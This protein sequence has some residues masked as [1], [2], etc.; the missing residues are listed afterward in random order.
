MSRLVAG[1]VP[2]PAS[3]PRLVL[4]LEIHI[5]QGYKTYWR[6]PGDA[7]G[8]PPRFDWSKS[9]NLKS[10]KTLFPA[11]QRITD[12]AGALIGYKEHIVFPI[13]VEAIDPARPIRLVAN[14]E[15]GVCKEICRLVQA[16]HALTIRTTK[17]YPLPPAL[18]Q[19]LENVPR[20]E[21]G[22]R[23]ADPR[24]TAIAARL[25]GTK[26]TLRFDVTVP[27]P[28]RT[29]IDL[30][31]ESLSDVHLPMTRLIPSRTT[32]GKGSSSVRFE[33]AIPPDIDSASLRGKTL[34]ITAVSPAGA[35]EFIRI[36][37]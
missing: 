30:F 25:G 12:P 36:L 6:H 28:A 9:Q 32:A 21:Q 10:A 2:L 35:S 37:K 4:G 23:P 8:I 18:H 17:S 33:I 29:N 1:S 22:L 19:A 16:R 27:G 15:F 14:T 5:E 13:E 3:P 24:L 34:R 7:G 31:V 11:P 26:P 20:P